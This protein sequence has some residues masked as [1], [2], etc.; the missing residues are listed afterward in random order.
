[1]DFN[2]TVKARFEELFSKWLGNGYEIICISIGALPSALHIAAGTRDCVVQVWKY[3][4]STHLLANVFSVQLDATVPSSLSFLNNAS[5][6]V[7]VFGL[8]NGYVYV[9]LPSTILR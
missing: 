8:Y 1:M 2:H 4:E 6:D 7:K 3:D 9:E 5:R